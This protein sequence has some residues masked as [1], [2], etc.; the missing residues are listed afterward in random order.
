MCVHTFCLQFQGLYG[1]LRLMD[2]MFR[3]SA[4]VGTS[5]SAHPS[6]VSEATELTLG[7]TKYVLSVVP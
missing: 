2:T 6:L 4:I 7:H 5:V 3:N 1:P